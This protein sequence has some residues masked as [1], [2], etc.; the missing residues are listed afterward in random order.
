MEFLKLLWTGIG[1]P[2]INVN[3][4]IVYF[5][6]NSNLSPFG[7]STLE[8]AQSILLLRSNLSS[9]SPA[10]FLSGKIERINTT[11]IDRSSR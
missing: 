2:R 7:V 1:Q 8:G 10:S 11:P 5:I 9:Q 3:L 4:V 6:R